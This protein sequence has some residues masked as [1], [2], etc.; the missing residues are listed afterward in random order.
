MEAALAAQTCLVEPSVNENEQKITEVISKCKV[1]WVQFW[2]KVSHFQPF[3]IKD[4][5]DHF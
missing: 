5:N 3:S 1:L 4:L 2:F